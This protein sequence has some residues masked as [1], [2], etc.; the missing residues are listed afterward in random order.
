MR[1]DI[2][3]YEYFY[4]NNLVKYNLIN[5]FKDNNGNIEIEKSKTQIK[6]RKRKKEEDR[7]GGK[8]K[9]EETLLSLFLSE[10]EDCEHVLDFVIK[11]V[12]NLYL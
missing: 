11:F 7:G 12:I 4:H 1:E 2:L 10:V 9:E 6:T 3:F 5:E 8:E